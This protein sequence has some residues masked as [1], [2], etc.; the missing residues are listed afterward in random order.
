MRTYYVPG[1]KEGSEFSGSSSEPVLRFEPFVTQD[2]EISPTHALT[3]IFN[4]YCF[5]S[6]C[7]G[8]SRVLGSW[9]FQPL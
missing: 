2:T 4:R 7:L 8:A 1:S 9:N 5:L 3:A 6:L